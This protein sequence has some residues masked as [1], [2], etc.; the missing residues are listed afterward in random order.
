LHV[1]GAFGALAALSDK[2]R[3]LLRGLEQADSIALDLHKWLY[4]PFEAGCVLVRQAEDHEATFSVSAPYLMAIP[5]SVSGSG[6]NFKDHGLQLSRQFR[7]LKVWMSLKAEGV[8]KFGRLIEQNVAQAS[9]LARRVEDHEELELM[10]PVPL[11]VVCFRYRPTSH[12]DLDLDL[13]NR[14]I[15]T[16]L[17]RSGVAVPNS[18]LIRQEFA[19][20][21]AITN[22]RTR[23]E[24][25]DLLVSEV[26]RLG[27]EMVGRSGGA[28]A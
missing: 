21:V 10:A 24:D 11:N 20:R 6:F 27:R 28:P 26:A 8:K 19:I 14:E 7:A 3:P 15:L 5:G 22:H 2:Y 25:L 12:A 23:R 18:T 17:H 9:Y 13:I 4:M 16:E 1:D